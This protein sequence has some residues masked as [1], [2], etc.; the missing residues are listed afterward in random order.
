MKKLYGYTGKLLFVDLTTK[1][2]EVKD[3]SEEMAHNFLGGYGIG[4]KVLY[5]MMPKG[6]DPFAKESVIGFLAGPVTGTGGVMSAA[7]RQSTN[8]R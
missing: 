6:C 8:H 5:D 7:G 4:A 3:L 1:V 2:I